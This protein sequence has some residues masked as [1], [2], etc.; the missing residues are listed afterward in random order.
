MFLIAA[1]LAWDEERSNLAAANMKIA[2]LESEDH[3][4]RLRRDQ[5]ELEGLEG[6]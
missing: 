6:L 1:F 4:I 3:K 2:E 5:A